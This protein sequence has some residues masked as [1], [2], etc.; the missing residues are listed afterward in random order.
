MRYRVELQLR[1][2]LA[3]PVGVLRLLGAEVFAEVLQPLVVFSQLLEL[4]L[5]VLELGGGLGR[6]ARPGL[7]SFG[8]LLDLV[9]VVL[10][11]ALH[12]GDD[13]CV[14]FLHRAVH[15]LLDS[16]QH[17]LLALFAGSKAVH[18]R[19]VEQLFYRE[20]EP[21]EQRSLE[22]V[23]AASGERV[24]EVVRHGVI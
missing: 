7:V 11:L 19:V 12:A 6:V 18:Q 14:H 15:D 24:L 20:F 22:F 4:Q 5:E 8:Q 1:L 13:V 16:V 17:E 21:A 23:D 3:L 9:F 10:E 2:V